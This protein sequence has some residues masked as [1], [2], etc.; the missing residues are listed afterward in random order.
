MIGKRICLVAGC[1]VCLVATNIWGQSA[2]DEIKK[3]MRLSASN[4]MAYPGPQKQL[5]P[6]PNGLK[7]F[8]ISHY[9][10]HGSRYMNNKRE[11]TYPY[12][13]LLRADDAGKLTP[14]GKDV[15][16]RMEL[17]LA[18]ADMR[19]GELTPLGA[20][21]QREIARRMFERF[22]EVFEGEALVD[23]KSTT[24]IRCILSMSNALQEL[25]RLNPQL[26]ISCD[27]STHDMYYMNQTDSRLWNNKMPGDSKDV[28]DKYCEKHDRSARLVSS[29]INDT[30]Y[31]NHEMNAARLN[32]YL[33][34]MASNIQNMEVRKKL[35]LYDL[36]DDDEIYNNWQKE[37]TWWY[38]TFSFCPYN[39]GVQ[40][41]SQRNLL[42]HLIADA[43][44]CIA[45]EK[46]GVALRFGHETMVLPLACLLG[47]NGY[48]LE[49]T[50]LDQLERRGWR[51]YRIFP[52]AANIQLIFY[53]RHPLDEDVVVK[54]LL[55]EDEATLPI[56]TDMAPY[57]RWSD[58]R[59]YYL[60]RLSEYKE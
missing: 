26:R 32:Y 38:M 33:F 31:V 11:Y 53:R 12:E 48:D 60:K 13:T 29:L 54:V 15:L 52:M 16:R 2:R 24:V 6:A 10:R 55:N 9:G 18:E 49:T 57:Y 56:K 58:F 35:T 41:Y 22:P 42:R 37:N 21:Q 4:H 44:S 3:N 50:D 45:Q 28:Y 5:T 59:E 14:L 27:A 17:I 36:F 39:G 43:D 23:A 51:N 34:K 40:P 20:Q 25:S 30:A 7:P 47:I 19:R 46:P 1:L 8:Y